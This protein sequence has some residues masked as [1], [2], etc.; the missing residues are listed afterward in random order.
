MHP[1]RENG[2]YNHRIAEFEV[3]LLHSQ[4]YHALQTYMRSLK[5]QCLYSSLLTSER[6]WSCWDDDFRQKSLANVRKWNRV[7]KLE[8][9]VADQVR[10]L[11]KQRP[12]G[13]TQGAC[14]ESIQWWNDRAS[15][16]KWSPDLHMCALLCV[17]TCISYAHTYEPI[18][19]YQFAMTSTWNYHTLWV[20]FHLEWVFIPSFMWQIFL[21]SR[22]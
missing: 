9:K 3:S 2:K 11:A 4:E 17:T 10:T 22:S 12:A 7:A 5:Q 15:S 19:L 16:I 20:H 13:K 21:S 6:T 8:G 18:T 14:L 1:Q